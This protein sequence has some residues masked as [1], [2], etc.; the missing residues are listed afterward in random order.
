MI[1]EHIDEAESV[2]LADLDDFTEFEFK[3][4]PDE[5]IEEFMAARLPW[6]VNEGVRYSKNYI[7]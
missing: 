7:K 2:N 6:E 4:D 5:E 3:G 1:K